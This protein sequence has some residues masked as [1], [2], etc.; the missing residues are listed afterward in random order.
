M[1]DASACPCHWHVHHSDG[2]LLDIVNERLLKT[3][4]R[5]GHSAEEID[6]FST[7]ATR[8]ARQQLASIKLR[9]LIFAEDCG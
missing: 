1:C 7:V 4:A 8:A 5:T 3:P 2:V 9:S 6:D